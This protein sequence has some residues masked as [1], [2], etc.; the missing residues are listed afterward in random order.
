MK[1]L[2]FGP[3]GAGKG[4]QAELIAKEFNLKH[5]ST[6]DIFRKNIKER[7]ELGLKVKEIVDKGLLVPDELTL[8]ILKPELKNLEGHNGFILDGFPRTIAQAESLSK[9]TRI[10]KV[11]NLMLD[12]EEAIK[13]QTGRRI[14]PVCK[15]TYNV[16]IPALKPKNDE[17][18]DYD[19]AKLV[20]RPDGKLEIVKERLRVYHEQS[21]PVLDYYKDITLNID[22]SKS[23]DEIFDFIKDA[24]KKELL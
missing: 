24:L 8:Q 2:I 13:R 10:D 3:P 18:C 21:Q 15:R 1:L 17:R 6:G 23:I 22:A 16:N 11:L 5:I 9:I 12:D 14:C 19:N 4:T 20:E 7:T